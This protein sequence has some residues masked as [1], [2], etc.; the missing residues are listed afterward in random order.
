MS[1]ENFF[2]PVLPIQLQGYVLS[3]SQMEILIVLLSLADVQQAV[4]LIY[5]LTEH[6]CDLSTQAASG[7]ITTE[8]KIWRGLQLIDIMLMSIVEDSEH[9]VPDEPLLVTAPLSPSW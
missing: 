3:I 8:T 6:A 9:H 2:S 7:N 5:T 4:Y 1:G